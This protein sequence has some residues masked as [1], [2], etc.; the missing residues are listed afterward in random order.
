M[1]STYQI[2]YE[3]AV[4]LSSVEDPRWS[5][6]GVST[7]KHE[8]DLPILKKITAGNPT[9]GARGGSGQI[10]ASASAFQTSSTVP[11]ER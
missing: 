9:A 2:R 6:P 11:V 8:P 5:K 10:Y 4:R 3:G 7:P 1:M